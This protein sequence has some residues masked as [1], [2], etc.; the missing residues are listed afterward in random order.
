LAKEL[1]SQDLKPLFL[2]QQN[3]ITMA[4]MQQ[5]GVEIELGAEVAEGIYS[6]LVL[7]THSTS[8]FIIDFAN[9]MPGM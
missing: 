1:F 4:E 2:H 5:Y 8:E 3:H 7:I 9:V 6:N